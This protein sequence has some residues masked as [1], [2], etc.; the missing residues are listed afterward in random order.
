LNDANTAL[1]ASNE[2][3]TN[4]LKLKKKLEDD[5]EALNKKLTDE[6]RD[7]ATLDKVI[8]YKNVEV[9]KLNKFTGQKEGRARI[10]RHQNQLGQCHNLPRH[11]GPK[12]E[13]DRREIG[14]RQS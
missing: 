12:L 8:Q 7:K 11:T 3:N 5:L 10:K 1:A 2:E 13:S 4:L 6:Q 14:E 9:C